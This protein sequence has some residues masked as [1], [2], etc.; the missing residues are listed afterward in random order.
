MSNAKVVHC[1]LMC[2]FWRLA[3]VAPYDFVLTCTRIRKNAMNHSDSRTTVGD[4]YGGI[5]S[6]LEFLRKISALSYFKRK[7]TN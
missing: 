3:L 2:E 5:V 7:C 1:F 4:D 6:A